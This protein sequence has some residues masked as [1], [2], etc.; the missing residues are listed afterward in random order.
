[1]PSW[2]RGG[3]FAVWALIGRS[4]PPVRVITAGRSRLTASGPGAAVARKV[5][6]SAAARS[7]G[8]GE[9]D[10]LGVG[11]RPGVGAHDGAFPQ[12]RRLRLAG[13]GYRGGERRGGDGGQDGE[14][15]MRSHRA[16]LSSV[17]ASTIA[18][19]GAITA[20]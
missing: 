20:Q 4:E 11:R 17:K 9:G 15:A 1:M 12:D 8:A 13:P 19:N 14:Q 2:R 6:A 16:A 18:W 3:G 7:A 5:P 10:D